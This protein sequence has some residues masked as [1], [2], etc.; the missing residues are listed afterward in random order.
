M[1]TAFKPQLDDI[2]GIGVFSDMR[3]EQLEYLLEESVYL[4]INRGETPHPEM[5]YAQDI[6]KYIDAR[7]ERMSEL[8]AQKAH[9]SMEVD[10]TRTEEGMLE[11]HA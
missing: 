5:K 8:A 2:A 6:S 1:D 4:D 11:S 10:A 9:G 3:A 7:M